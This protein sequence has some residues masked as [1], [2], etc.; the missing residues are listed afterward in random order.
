MTNE[1]TLLAL[2]D[3][4]EAE[5]NAKAEF[6]VEFVNSCMDRA[7]HKLLWEIITLTSGEQERAISTAIFAYWNA[8]TAN[9]RE[10]MNSA[11]LAHFTALADKEWKSHTAVCQDAMNA[12]QWE[13]YQH[14]SAA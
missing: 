14:R 4:E 2:L 6:V 9:L 10:E 8:E 7:D 5:A 1:H 12:E 3:S 13:Q 11:I